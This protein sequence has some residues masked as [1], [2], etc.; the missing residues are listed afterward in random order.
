MGVKPMD[1]KV[2]NAL[3][4]SRAARCI[5]PPCAVVPRLAGVR[6][7][8]PTEGRVITGKMRMLSHVLPMH[9]SAA[10]EFPRV[11]IVNVPVCVAG[12]DHKL[13]VLFGAK[14]D[15]KPYSDKLEVMSGG[16]FWEFPVYWPVTSQEFEIP[17]KNGLHQ[18]PSLRLIALA[19]QF[20][21]QISVMN[22]QTGKTHEIEARD[23]IVTPA[24]IKGNVT[25]D[26][27]GLV[28]LYVPLGA[29]ATVQTKG[30]DA[31]AAMSAVKQFFKGF[32]EADWYRGKV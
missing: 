31:E 19:S 16:R 4:R 30:P 10:D 20:K 13:P 5:K 2:L 18:I 3:A 22:A 11:N 26:L 32:T 21:A 15:Q 14:H 28:E 17:W 27:L 12:K 25:E 29:R 6:A 24:G 8:I 1:N 23:V 7:W 9:L